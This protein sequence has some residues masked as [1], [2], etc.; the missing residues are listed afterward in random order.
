LVRG[1]CKGAGGGVEN[2]NVAV[3][4][5]VHC[6]PEVVHVTPLEI[7]LAP[8]LN[9]TVPVGPGPPLFDGATTAVSITLP[10]GVIVRGVAVNVV[11]VVGSETFTV[12][13]ALVLPA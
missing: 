7:V 5:A 6:I 10:P 9:V 3:R 2:A 11:V 13:A 12:I 1:T 4:V 8:F